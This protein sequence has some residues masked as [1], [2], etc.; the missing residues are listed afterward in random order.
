M[1]RIAVSVVLLL[2]LTTGATADLTNPSTL[3]LKET[4][5]TRFSVELTLPIIQGRV[6][7]VRPD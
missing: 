6:P 3:T 1:K 4:S 7:K 2:A 5:P